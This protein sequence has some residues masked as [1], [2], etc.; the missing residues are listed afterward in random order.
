MLILNSLSADI[1]GLISPVFGLEGRVFHKGTLVLALVVQDY[2]KVKLPARDNSSLA[3]KG[4]VKEMKEKTIQNCSLDII[5]N[6]LE[7]IFTKYLVFP[8]NIYNFRKTFHGQSY[9]FFLM[10]F[11]PSMVKVFVSQTKSKII[12]FCKVSYS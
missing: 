11:R 1:F 8:K 3:V 10:T 7:T 6:L 5:L 9:K 4:L 2:K 12:I